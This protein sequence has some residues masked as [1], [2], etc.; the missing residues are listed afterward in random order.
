MKSQTPQGLFDEFLAELFGQDHDL[1]V[2]A[3][4]AVF[5]EHGFPPMA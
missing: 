3:K 4:G 5:M 2:K 1:V